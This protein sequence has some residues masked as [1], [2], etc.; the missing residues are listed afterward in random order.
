MIDAVKEISQSSSSIIDTAVSVDGSWQRREF[1][2]LN[3]VVTAIS[4]DTVKILDC[5]P[6]SRSCKE[7]SLNLKLK[8]SNPNA[9]ETWKSS[10]LCKLNYRGSAPGMELIGAQRMFCRSISQ[11][12]LRYINYY[13][14]GDCKSYS[15]IKDTYP[16]I[17]V[18]KLECV[19]HVKKCVVSRLRNLK[20]TI[21]GL[22]EGKEN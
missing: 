22:G 9:F 10:H 3:G 7:C 14:D 6:L 21:K 16:G 2:S 5:E 13:G 4:I 19:G 18:C 15:Y 1:S 17:A 20:K 8:E 12:K 11:N